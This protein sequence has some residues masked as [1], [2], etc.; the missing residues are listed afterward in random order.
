MG[1]RRATLGLLGVCLPLW[2]GELEQ[3]MAL[4]RAYLQRGMAA[5][6]VATWESLAKS[7]PDNAHVRYGLGLAYFAAE[8]FEESLASLVE[9]IRLQPK[10]SEFY[11][12]AANCAAALYR[13]P[14]A[15]AYLDAA[16]QLTPEGPVIA[17]QRAK[18][19]AQRGQLETAFAL[20][21]RAKALG[22]DAAECD[23]ERG[24]LLF[25][26]GRRPE[27]LAA[28]DAA[29]EANPSHLG[30]RYTR[31]QVRRRLGDLSGAETDLKIH[32]TLKKRQTELDA[33]RASILR[34]ADP[35]TRAQLWANLGRALLSYGN[36][37]AAAEAYEAAFTVDSALTLAYVGHAAA[38][39]AQGNYA[40]AEASA[41]KALEQDPHLV[42][43]TGLLGEIA[44]RRGEFQ[45]ALS[46]LATA[47]ARK[48]EL[49]VARRAY[50]ETLLA[51]GRAEA[52]DEFAKALQQNP[53]D[54]ALHDGMARALAQRGNSL[55]EALAHAQRAVELDPTSP[56]FWNTL[57]LIAFRLRRYDDAEN[58]LLRALELRPDSENYRAG[59][60]AVRKARTSP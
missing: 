19:H 55:D 6:A 53:T 2:G 49:S 12:A 8:R 34:T 21:E 38:M 13:Y 24:R 4:G 16:E 39:A 50:A 28:L 33:I 15:L 18:I 42:E 23:F 5:E 14:E 46:L 30:A 43:A 27:A 41:S 25:R 37:N 10:R 11:Q 52:L 40:A 56:P 48:P 31:S 54:P 51:L 45:R 32:E 47:L 9:A 57:A 3:K 60:D 17:F 44:F 59:L 29:L 7:A 20:F 58:A 35:K 1:W 22:Y 36:A 26:L